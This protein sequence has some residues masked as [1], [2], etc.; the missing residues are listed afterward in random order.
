MSTGRFGEL[1]ATVSRLADWYRSEGPPTLLYVAL[2]LL[3]YSASFQG[4]Q[5]RAARLFDESATVDVPAR[6]ISVNAPIDA[7]SAF[8]RG[9]RARAF[10]ILR[11]HVDEL[12]RTGYSD[13]ASNAAVEFVTMMAVI[14]HVDD[15]APVLG[16]LA[17][18]GDFG[19]LAVRTL[20]ADAAV[21]ITAGV[22]GPG[23]Q[24]DAHRALEFM[25]DVLDRLDGSSV[26]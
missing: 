18:A 25:R 17:V 21:G 8:R 7:R 22:G 15:A 13:I 5:E 10:R 1:D 20:V 14:G 19:A 26:D 11:R 12:L 24:L 16:Y 2:T 23:H 4:E 3:G 6:T 9:D